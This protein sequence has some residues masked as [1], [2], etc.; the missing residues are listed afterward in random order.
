MSNQIQANASNKVFK[1]LNKEFIHQFVF[2]F[3]R[4]AEKQNKRKSCTGKKIQDFIL[5]IL[6]GRLSS[7]YTKRNLNEYK[8]YPSKPLIYIYAKCEPLFLSFFFFKTMSSPK[9]AQI[10]Y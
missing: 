4:I 1:I 9:R 5:W 6:L 8:E 3:W 2:V 7:L 10:F